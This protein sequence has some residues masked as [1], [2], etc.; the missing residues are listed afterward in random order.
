M[1]KWI[2]PSHARFLSRWWKARR[3]ALCGERVCE[4]SKRR[5]FK[6]APLHSN[7]QAG[8]RRTKPEPLHHPPD[9]TVF[10]PECS[11]QYLLD[12]LFKCLPSKVGRW[13]MQ[14]WGGL[15]GRRREGPPQEQS[16]I[17][18]K[19]GVTVNL[20][21]TAVT[22]ESDQGWKLS[23]VCKQRRELLINGLRC[24]QTHTNTVLGVVPFNVHLHT[25]FAQFTAKP[26]C[27]AA[28]AHSHKLVLPSN[29]HGGALTQWGTWLSC[30]C[31]E[32]VSVGY[33]EQAKRGKKNKKPATMSTTNI[34]WFILCWGQTIRRTAW[35]ASGLLWCQNRCFYVCSLV[36]ETE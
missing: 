1:S 36:L 13:S 20:K 31:D 29:I 16:L 4:V 25:L 30:V 19:R 7:V 21:S 26:A 24:T 18:T 5:D 3:R 10:K 6:N 23:L 22:A 12:L 9:A 27:R 35:D 15:P 14:V 11:N 28:G 17:G 32:L 8:G 34:M 33:V 2:N